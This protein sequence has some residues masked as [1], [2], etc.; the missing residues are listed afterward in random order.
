MLCEVCGRKEE[1]A[2]LGIDGKEETYVCKDCFV[3]IHDIIG[4]EDS[5][6]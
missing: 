6:D 4:P 3:K 2:T 5:E 1:M